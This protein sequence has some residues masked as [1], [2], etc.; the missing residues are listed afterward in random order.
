MISKYGDIM[1]LA[2]SKI[3][4]QVGRADLRMILRR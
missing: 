4:K 1:S 2:V 3:L